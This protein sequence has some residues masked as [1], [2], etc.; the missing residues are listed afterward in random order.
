MGINEKMTSLANEVRRLS[1][2][3][4]KLGIDAMTAALKGIAAGQSEGLPDGYVQLTHIEGD[5]TR[6]INTRFTPNQDTRVVMRCILPPSSSTNWLFGARDDQKRSEFGFGYS[7]SGNYNTTYN[8]THKKFDE[9]MDSDGVILIDKNKSVTTITAN[10]VT[11]TVTGTSGSFSTSATI[12]LF[13]MNTSGTVTVGK[14]I[15]LSCEIYDNGSLV[16]NYIPACKI[17]TAEVGMYDTVGNVFDPF[18]ASAGG[19]AVYRG[20]VNFSTAATSVSIDIGT[21]LNASDTFIMLKTGASS[22]GRDLIT[23]VLC[24]DEESIATYAMMDDGVVSR[25]YDADITLGGS[26]VSFASPNSY[27]IVHG[28]YTWFVIKG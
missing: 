18:V 20:T 25:V 8:T 3:S 7:L 21:T 14:G 28:E 12:V 11:E 2:E 10:G 23:C 19:N 27:T 13:G 4:G 9:S 1:G 6:Y 22:D 17:E 16:R 5:G 15:I 24:D 26:T